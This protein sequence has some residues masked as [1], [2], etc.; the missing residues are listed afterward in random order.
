MAGGAGEVESPVLRSVC[1]KG[2]GNA[3]TETPECRYR[4]RKKVPADRH[5]FPE[6]IILRKISY[7]KRGRDMIEILGA[8]KASDSTNKEGKDIPSLDMNTCEAPL[9]AQSSSRADATRASDWQHCVS[10]DSDRRCFLLEGAA[11]EMPRHAGP[12]GAAVGTVGRAAIPAQPGWANSMAC[13]LAEHLQPER[14]S[15]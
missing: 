13:S 2:N 7:L 5:Q 6:C 4:A 15:E 14:D 8:R 12:R 11:R 9:L 1:C 10:R 3:D